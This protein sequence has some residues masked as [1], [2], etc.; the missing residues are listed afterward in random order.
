MFL[1]LRGDPQKGSRTFIAEKDGHTHTFE[2]VK[3]IANM[4]NGKYLEE[5]L[6]DTTPT[7]FCIGVAGYPEKH[8]EAPNRQVDMKTLSIKL[9]Q[10]QAILLPRCFLI[11]VNSSGSGMNAERSGLLFLLLQG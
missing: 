11:T 9:N 7:Y 2:L 5:S 1:H 8:F 6:E 3:Q 4:N 10:E